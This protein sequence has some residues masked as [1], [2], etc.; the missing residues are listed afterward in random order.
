MILDVGT[1]KS[2]L[3]VINTQRLQEDSTPAVQNR[4][5]IDNSSKL[6]Q[7]LFVNHFSSVFYGDVNLYAI[8][9]KLVL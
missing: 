2:K 4:D 5:T 8:G 7:L 6:Y 1:I 3:S 9:S